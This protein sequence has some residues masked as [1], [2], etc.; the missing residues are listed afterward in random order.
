M[1]ADGSFEDIGSTLLSLVK[2]ILLI[3]IR[4]YVSLTLHPL[5][6][7]VRFYQTRGF[8]WKRRHIEMI[9]HPSYRDIFTLLEQY[10]AYKKVV[11]AKFK[12][13]Y[14]TYEREIKRQYLMQLMEESEYQDSFGG[15]RII[16]ERTR[17][18]KRKNKQSLRKKGY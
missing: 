6:R 5:E 2:H 9:W 14:S 17:I 3:H 4:P 18:K 10:P 11:R 13:Y 12:K 16:T 1:C 8:I 15:R 7:A